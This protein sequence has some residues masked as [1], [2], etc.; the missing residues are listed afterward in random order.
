L[1]QQNREGARPGN[2]NCK[3]PGGLKVPGGLGEGGDGK[4]LSISVVLPAFTVAS[5]ITPEIQPPKD[6][7]NTVAKITMPTRVAASEAGIASRTM[8]A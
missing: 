1:F 2:R 3:T 5:K 4:P 6:M 7:P 8:I